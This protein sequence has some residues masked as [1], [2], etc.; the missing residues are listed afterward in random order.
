MKYSSRSKALSLLVNISIG[1][2]GAWLIFNPSSGV[3]IFRFYVG[4]ILL[5]A[6]GSFLFLYSRS[7]EKDSMQL[8]QALVFGAL[9]IIFL[10]SMA[11]ASIFLGVVLMIWIL[12]EGLVNIK[13]AFTY[14]KFSFEGWWILLLYG[15]GAIALGIYVMLNLSISGKALVVIVGIFTLARS[16]I[17]VIDTLLYKERYYKMTI[18]T[19]K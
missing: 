12:F 10:I 14:R 18:K 5:I 8:F 4:V 16:I 7:E 9:G 1:I 2:L 11:V 6:S 17:E 15:I 19:K 13:L 3:E